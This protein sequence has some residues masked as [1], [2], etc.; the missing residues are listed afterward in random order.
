M[1]A[2]DM[3]D[4]VRPV[5]RPNVDIWETL[6]SLPNLRNSKDLRNVPNEKKSHVCSTQCKFNTIF[7]LNLG[8]VE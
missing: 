3:T 2:T 6:K 5:M 7:L 1:K 8:G 4:T